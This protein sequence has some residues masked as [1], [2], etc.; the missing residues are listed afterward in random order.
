MS[1]EIL[2]SIVTHGFSDQ[3]CTK[4]LSKTK[5][6]LY[7]NHHFKSTVLVPLHVGFANELWMCIIIH[8]EFVK[9]RK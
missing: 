5:Q 3:P 9:Y 7:S 6:I 2:F 8:S 4:I 1:K